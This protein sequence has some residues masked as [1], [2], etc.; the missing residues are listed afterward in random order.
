[1][2]KKSLI[3]ERFE[4]NNSKL[5][6]LAF[7]SQRAKYS[8]ELQENIKQNYVLVSEPCFCGDQ[9][10]YIIA[11][12]DR[13]GIPINSVLCNS[14]G[15]IR[16]DPYL[17]QESADHFY[18]N[19][20]QGLYGRSVDKEEYFVRQEKYGNKY[21][22]IAAEIL[23]PKDWVLEIGC[24]AGGALFVFQK[25]GFQVAGVDFDQN[26]LDYGR[27]R[28]VSNLHYGSLDV[29]KGELSF[30]AKLI[31]LNHVFEH[32][33]DPKKML[34]DC[35][36]FLD[37]EGIILI[38]VPDL[39]GIKSD[40]AYGGDLI[41]MIH[42]AHK[43]NYSFD[44]I[45]YLAN[46]N[47]F[48]AERIFPD[49]SIKTHTSNAGEMW[50][51]LKNEKGVSNIGTINEKYGIKILNQLRVYEKRYQL[52]LFLKDVNKKIYKIIKRLQNRIKF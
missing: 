3:S 48:K 34:E 35:K 49:Q 23:S 51:L 26:L 45:N 16:I 39:L 19:I 52:Y 42:I 11:E 36:E 40:D 32:L 44:G 50:I 17:D 41:N 21:Y 20:Y 38:A 30:K 5:K 13:Y 8:V 25:K 15:T 24:G 18:T 43:Y 2:I 33:I 22:S 28:G 7:D 47:G 29:L 10:G 27:S 37:D 46:A 12:Y 31:Y 9:T 6:I 14:C 4:K 1:M